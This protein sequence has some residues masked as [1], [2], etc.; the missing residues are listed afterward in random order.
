MHAEKRGRERFK[1]GGEKDAAHLLRLK[2]VDVLPLGMPTDAPMSIGTRFTI[3][4][5]RQPS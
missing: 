1:K 5:C 3:T 4:E 2:N